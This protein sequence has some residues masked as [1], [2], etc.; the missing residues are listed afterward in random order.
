MCVYVCVLHASVFVRARARA[1]VRLCV[2][3]CVRE[4]VLGAAFDRAR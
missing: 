2:R 3:A 4:Y 1:F